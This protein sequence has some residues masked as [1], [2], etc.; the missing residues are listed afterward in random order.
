MVAAVSGLAS[1]SNMVSLIAQ[2]IVILSTVR[3][4]SRP[5]IAL[6]PLASIGLRYAIRQFV[7]QSQL[8][9]LDFLHYLMLSHRFCEPKFE[10]RGQLSA[11]VR[12]PPGC[13]EW[14]PCRAASQPSLQHV[15]E[16]C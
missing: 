10:P 5:V 7:N 8:L 13:R 16:G 14:L 3:L 9:P 4:L 6:L 11:S 15:R 2:A 1:I 12:M